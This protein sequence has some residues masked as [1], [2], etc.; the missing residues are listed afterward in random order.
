MIVVIC[1][2]VYIENFGQIGNTIVIIILATIAYA[3]VLLIMKNPIINYG[4]RLI[5][6]G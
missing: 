3:C 6:R 4:K 1:K 2:N 5:R